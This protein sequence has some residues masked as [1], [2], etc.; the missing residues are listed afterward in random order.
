MV[1]LKETM[2]IEYFSQN[3]HESLSAGMMTFT[4]PFYIAVY[5]T[6]PASW[7]PQL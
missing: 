3:F 2:N 5:F 6:N 4:V 7:L 1:L